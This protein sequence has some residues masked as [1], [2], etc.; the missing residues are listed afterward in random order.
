MVKRI[1][2]G[3][4]DDLDGTAADERIEFSVA[5]VHYEIDLSTENADKMRGEFMRWS[6]LGRRVDV[7]R[8]A[9]Q[10]AARRRGVSPSEGFAIRQWCDRN[11]FSV[12]GRGRLPI[13]AIDAFRSANSDGH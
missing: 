1:T 7:K 3:F 11:G 12:S 8:L 10:G 6:D 2:V 5:G 9:T 4:V 13:N